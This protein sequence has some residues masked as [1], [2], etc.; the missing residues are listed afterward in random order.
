[1]AI[2]ASMV[3]ADMQTII[4]ILMSEHSALEKVGQQQVAQ[5][6]RTQTLE[7]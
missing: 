1:M 6:A 7:E 4:T 3:M 2:T 5:E